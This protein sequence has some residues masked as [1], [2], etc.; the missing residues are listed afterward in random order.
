M[1]NVSKCTDPKTSV[2][3]NPEPSHLPGKAVTARAV[4]EEMDTEKETR[5]EA[6]AEEAREIMAPRET[7]SNETSSPTKIQ[8]KNH[9][10][11]FPTTLTTL[12]RIETSLETSQ[13]GEA[14]AVPEETV[15]ET[16]VVTRVA[17]RVEEDLV[18]ET[19]GATREV[20]REETRAEED[21]ALGVAREETRAEARVVVVWA[22]GEDLTSPKPSPRL[23][24]IR[25]ILHAISRKK[26]FFIVTSLKNEMF[27]QV[28]AKEETRA[29]VTEIDTE[30]A[31]VV[32]ETRVEEIRAVE[33][34]VL[35]TAGE[36]RAEPRAVEETVLEIV[37]ETRAV[38][39]VE[40]DI[41][42][43]A[44]MVVARVAARAAAVAAPEIPLKHQEI[45]RE[46][47]HHQ[48]KQHQS[49][50]VCNLARV[51]ILSFR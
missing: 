9:E 2:T 20:T 1:T 32:V 16:A 44:V 13:R 36:T 45:P 27:Q 18:L 35:E 11:N 5:E 48:H 46:R 24:S 31:T 25:E 23:K 51:S 40:V 34:L 14:R 28:E 4:G 38:P 37:V 26:K 42:V 12:W 33:D 15:Q 22:A 19:V 29:V 30:P 3:L 41:E 39:R 47:P 43:E 10:K 50:D 6:T 7:V 8:T 21:L 17:P 49:E